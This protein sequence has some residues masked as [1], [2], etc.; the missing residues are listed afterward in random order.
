MHVRPS[1]TNFKRCEP[2]KYH[3]SH[4]KND[5]N[6]EKTS[7]QIARSIINLAVALKANT[8]I[9]PISIITQQNDHL[10]NKTSKLDSPLVNICGKRH[11]PVIGH[12]EPIFP[13]TL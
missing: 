9:I 10:N 6:S 11:V 13:D 1:E 5:L 12:S 7:S 4:W 2:G 3:P 8:Y